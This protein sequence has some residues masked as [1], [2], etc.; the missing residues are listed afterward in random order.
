MIM[1]IKPRNPSSASPHKPTMVPK[2]IASHISGV[3]VQPL[4]YVQ[5]HDAAEVLGYVLEEVCKVTNTHQLLPSAFL[6]C[7]HVKCALVVFLNHHLAILVSRFFIWLCGS[8]LL[9]LCPRCYQEI[10]LLNIVI[11]VNLTKNFF[12]NLRPPDW[13]YSD[14]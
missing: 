13:Q 2:S 12:V 6:H 9:I 5:Q 14:L 11:P 7:I 10:S 4:R 8:Q 3:Q 1:N